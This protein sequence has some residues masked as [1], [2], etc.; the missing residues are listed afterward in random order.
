VQASSLAIEAGFVAD[1][2]IGGV[3]LLVNRIH[4]GH[5]VGALIGTVFGAVLIRAAR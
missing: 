4:L 1:M 5:Y 3:F 2:V